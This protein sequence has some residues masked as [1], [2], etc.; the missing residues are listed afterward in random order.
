MRFAP[1]WLSWLPWVWGDYWIL[2]LA[3]DG[4]YS[5]VG[6]PNRRY[7]WVLSRHEQ[8]DPKQMQKLLDYAQDLG[9]DIQDIQFESTSNSF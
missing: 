8:A 6:S 2:A 5:I 1:E 7:L 9:F 4:D 3:D